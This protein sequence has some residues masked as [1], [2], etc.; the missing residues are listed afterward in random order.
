MLVWGSE[1][2]LQPIH[3]KLEISVLIDDYCKGQRLDMA[4]SYSMNLGYPL[5]IPT[6]SI[7]RFK[8]I[9]SLIKEK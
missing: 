9:S 3:I 1:M 4:A 8:Q 6:S 7:I 2:L 5:V